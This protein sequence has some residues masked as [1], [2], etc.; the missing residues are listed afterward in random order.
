MI[1]K[2]S[3]SERS[4]KIMRYKH[5]LFIRRQKVSISRNFTGRSRVALEK[6]RNNGKFTRPSLTNYELPF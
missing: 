3:I 2:L 5:K 4:K 6:K 1:G